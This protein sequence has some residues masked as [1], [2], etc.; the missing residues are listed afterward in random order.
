MAHGLWDYWEKTREYKGTADKCYLKYNRKGVET[1]SAISPI[2]LKQ[3]FVPFVILLC[4]W[5]IGFFLFLRERMYDYLRSQEEAE[6]VVDSRPAVNVVD[7]NQILVVQDVNIHRDAA[8]TEDEDEAM[9]NGQII[10]HAVIEVVNKT[11]TANNQNIE[12]ENTPD[13][14]DKTGGG[15]KVVSTQRA[16]VEVI[17]NNMETGVGQQQGGTIKRDKDD[18]VEVNVPDIEKNK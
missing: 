4:G 14:T 17:F 12:E 15:E 16:D 7:R 10:V 5:L 3:L 8:A 13:A 11:D 6:N 18:G 1:Q 2:Q 9:D